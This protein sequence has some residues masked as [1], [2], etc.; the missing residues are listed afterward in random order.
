MYHPLRARASQD[1]SNTKPSN[2][3]ATKARSKRQCRSYKQRRRAKDKAKG[4]GEAEAKAKDKTNGRTTVK[5]KSKPKAAAKAM[6]HS[7]YAPLHFL[8]PSFVLL[9]C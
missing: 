7:P 5:A 2:E 9:Q 1:G 8:H 3:E 4:K 6:L